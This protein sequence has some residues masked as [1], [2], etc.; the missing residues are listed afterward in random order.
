MTRARP[1]CVQWGNGY[2]L[3][4][5]PTCSPSPRGARA[6]DALA[7]KCPNTR[8]QPR[9]RAHLGWVAVVAGCPGQGMNCAPGLKRTTSQSIMSR[10]GWAWR[11]RPHAV[12]FEHTRLFTHPF[13]YRPRPRRRL[14]RARG[15]SDRSR[16]RGKRQGPAPHEAAHL[17][18]PAQST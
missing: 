14:A 7:A 8:R 13:I 10:R 16:A 17:P 15:V 5:R 18:T 1:F 11:F 12:G 4:F 9:H 2:N 3:V 6:T